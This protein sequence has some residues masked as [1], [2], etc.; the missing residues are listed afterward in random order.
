VTGE[1]GRGSMGEGKRGRRL[2]VDSRRERNR[3]EDGV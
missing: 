3:I 1:I 2:K